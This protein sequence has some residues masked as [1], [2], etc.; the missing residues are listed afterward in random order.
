MTTSDSPAPQP[1]PARPED[2]DLFR[3]ELI[4][5][6]AWDVDRDTEEFAAWHSDQGFQRLG[7]DQGV[8]PISQAEARAL[9]ERWRDDWPSSDFCHV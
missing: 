1:V 5:V 8:R 4:R 9:M 6:D 2:V 7:Y 3:G